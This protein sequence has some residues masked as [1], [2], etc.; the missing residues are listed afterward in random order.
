MNLQP[1]LVPYWNRFFFE[2]IPA[3]PLAL[4][5]IAFGTVV[6]VNMA[7]LA[8][9]T[10]VWYGERG[11]L[12]PEF[13]AQIIN[14]PHVSLF[15]VLPAGDAAAWG[16]MIGTLAAAAC[17]LAGWQTRLASILLWLCLVSFH[18][19][20]SF[21]LNSS[22]TLLRNLAFLM[23]FAPSGRALSLDRV[24]RRRRGRE[25]P[26]PA[27]IV[28]WAQRLLQ[29]QVC[30]MYL[31]TVLWKISGP[32]W[33]DGTA[34]YYSLGLEEFAHY[35]I[36]DFMHTLFFSRLAT[37]GTLLVEGSLATLIWVPR[38]RPYVLCCGLA[39][40]L[41]LEYAMNIPI[42]QWAALSTYC[43]FLDPRGIVVRAVERTFARRPEEP[44]LGA[45]NSA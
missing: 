24:L 13:A 42:F 11:T 3:T 22:D 27:L 28:P 41:G 35:P 36:P 40:H 43:L 25:A 4:F 29:I 45:P 9:D 32:M 19:R 34:V 39:L 21:L 44:H 15:S 17:V 8:P 5:R 23:M 1:Q 18:Q 6:L 14:W 31:S 38:L 30:V 16:V 10:L 37:W 7:L 2:P 20:N 12:P 26:G 33:I